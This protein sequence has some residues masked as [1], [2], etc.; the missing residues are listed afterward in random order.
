V[1]RLVWWIGTVV[2]VLCVLGLLR[3]GVG[4]VVVALLLAAVAIWWWLVADK[5]R[6][7]VAISKW[8]ASH[9]QRPE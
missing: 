8:L 1:K 3:T 4:I 5:Q 2:A 9:G 7:G 6:I